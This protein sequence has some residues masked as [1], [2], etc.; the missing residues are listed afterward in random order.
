MKRPERAPTAGR[1]GLPFLALSALASASC[2]V[3]PLTMPAS[4]SRPPVPSDLK[5]FRAGFGRADITP[6]PG[7]GLNAYGP[8]GGIARGHRHRL[9]ARA[10]VLED[11][12]GERIALVAVDLSQP[13]LLLHREVATR[14]A[15]D[16]GIGADRLALSGTH[17]HSGPGHYFGSRA[18][19]DYAP[20]IR[21]FDPAVVEFLA[22]RIAR[23]VDDAEAGLTSAVAAWSQEPV[24]GFTENRSYAAHVRNLNKGERPLPT[25]DLSPPLL[26][27]DPTWTLLRIDTIS[28]DGD[29]VPAGALSVFA[30]HPTGNPPANDLYDG[31]VSAL[32]ERGLE[33]HI[34]S[35]A[36][37]STAWATGAVHLLVNG[38]EGD[39]RLAGNRREACSRPAQRSGFRPGGPR[40]PAALDEW[41]SKDW[42]TGS[43]CVS[44]ARSFVNAVGDSLAARAIGIYDRARTGLRSDVAIGRAFR[45]VSLTGPRAPGDL[46]PEARIGGGAAAGSEEGQSNLKDWKVL[47]I[48]SLGAEEGAVDTGRQDCHGPKLELPW[49]LRAGL[50]NLELPTDMQLM[51]VRVGGLVLAMVPAEPTTEVGFRLRTAVLEAGSS[52][53]PA[54]ATAAVVG[55]TNG[56]MQ[57]AATLEEYEAQHYEGA[58]TLYGP[59]FAEVLEREIVDMVGQ[60]S[61]KEEP[62]VDPIM[63]RPGSRRSLFPHAAGTRPG[64]LVTTA[65]GCRSDTMVVRWLDAAPG[66]LLPADG[67]ILG[68]QKTRQDEETISTWDDDRF[69]EV[70]HIEGWGRRGH[71]WEARWTPRGG[72]RGTYSVTFLR[73]PAPTN[74]RVFRCP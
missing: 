23:A 44:N 40:T 54:V 20:G 4:V 63:A 6:P 52:R 55:L 70:R 31:D 21:G 39:V 50:G 7:L 3:A 37:T 36:G 42:K 73:W 67:P 34:D 49:L 32:I 65:A 59:A 51:L 74:T 45:T 47:G 12:D 9:Y 64:D 22:D 25:Q 58:S 1:I 48:L 72:T 17:T 15:S 66:D 61:R 41:R 19:N 5:T 71:L 18:Y 29:T 8:A 43:A 14:I 16:T 24:W 10:M 56:Y 62:R 35:L 38:A 28:A 11:A 57:Y 68:L 13:S 53:L 33:R 69:V 27:V 2:A 26:A 46:C 30:F 60:L